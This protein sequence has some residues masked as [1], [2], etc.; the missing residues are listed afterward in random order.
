MDDASQV[1]VTVVSRRG[2]ETRALGDDVDVDGSRAAADAEDVP[3]LTRVG[4]VDTDSIVRGRR[5][6]VGSPLVAVVR[7]RL[8]VDEEPHHRVG[9]F[10]REIVRVTVARLVVRTD[11][12]DVEKECPFRT[13]P[14]RESS[15]GKVAAA[16]WVNIGIRVLRV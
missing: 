15:L 8:G 4:P 7:M 9:A 10:E 16:A 11:R 13:V 12:A 2:V 3:N 6:I 1:D 14:N 5:S